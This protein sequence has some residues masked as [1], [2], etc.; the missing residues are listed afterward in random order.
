MIRYLKIIFFP[1]TCYFLLHTSCWAYTVVLE[2]NPNTEPD[3]AGYIVYYGTRSGVYEKEVD[4][5]NITTSTIGALV[6][7]VTYYFAVTAYDTEGLESGFSHETQYPAAA[8]PPNTAP[9]S[10]G[11]GGGGGCFVQSSAFNS[12]PNSIYLLL[13][14]S[15]L[16]IF[17]LSLALLTSAHRWKHK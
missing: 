8:P 1:M 9:S 15:G 2:W 11:G 3:L 4:V 6:R 16:V 14:L 12:L 7:G 13:S 10:G 17:L 5:G